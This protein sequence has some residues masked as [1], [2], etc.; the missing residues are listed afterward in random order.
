MCYD[1]MC[2]D[3]RLSV[4]NNDHDTLLVQYQY[5]N[6]KCMNVENPPYCKTSYDC[7]ILSILPHD[8][9]FLLFLCWK[10][11]QNIIHE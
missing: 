3:M 5:D 4:G 2:I 9:I 11:R 10:Y 8:A 7:S 6:E 1:C